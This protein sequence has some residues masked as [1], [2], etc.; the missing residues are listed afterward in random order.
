MYAILSGI[1]N[2]LIMPLTTSAPTIL[3]QELKK[4]PVSNPVAEVPQVN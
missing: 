1:V 2:M 3:Y 4:T